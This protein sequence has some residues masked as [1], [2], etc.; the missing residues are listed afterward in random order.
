MRMVPSSRQEIQ[1]ISVRDVL[2]QSLNDIGIGRI[3][4]EYERCLTRQREPVKFTINLQKL[5]ISNETMFPTFS[6][7]F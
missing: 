4:S 5:W 7:V 2:I 1:G 6:L 3:T